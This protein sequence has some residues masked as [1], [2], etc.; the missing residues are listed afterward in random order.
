ME[1]RD[2]KYGLRLMLREYT[3]DGELVSIDLLDCFELTTAERILSV[4]G[5]F[6]DK[7]KHYLINHNIVKKEV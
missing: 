3:N 5:Y 6:S 2:N 7:L 1:K 4:N